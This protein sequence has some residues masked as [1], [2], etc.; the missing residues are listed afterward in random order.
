MATTETYQRLHDQ[1]PVFSYQSFAYTLVQ[2]DF[3]CAF[4]YH[5]APDLTFQHHVTFHQVDT[6][7]LS[8]QNQKLLDNLVFHLGLIEMFSYWKL[9]ASPLIRIE[10]G[11]LSPK[12]LE[13]WHQLLLDGMGEYFYVNQIPFF[14]T[15]FVRLEAKNNTASAPQDC[16]HAHQG[17][18]SLVNLGGGKDSATMLTMLE[19]SNEDFATFIIQP[20]SPAARTQ[21]ELSHRTL[22]TA[23]RR[24]DPQLTQL[25]VNGYLNGHVPFSASV[26]FINLLA[27]VFYD[28]DFCLVGNEASADEVSLFWQNQPINHQFSKST[29]F[30]QSFQTYCSQYLINNVKYFSLLRPFNEFQIA[31]IFC[32]NPLFFDSARSCNR[33]Q[34]QNIWCEHCPKCL[35]VYLLLSAFLPSE[36]LHTRI[37][38][39]SLLDD[40]SLRE[41][42]SQLLGLATAKPLE[43][44]GTRD[45]S[46]AA[47]YLLYTN[48]IQSQ[49]PLPSLVAELAPHVLATRTNWEDFV[50][51][52][53]AS[54]HNSDTLPDW[55]SDLAHHYHR[56][57]PYKNQT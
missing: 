52:L 40:S 24:F 38:S 7:H 3:D 39:H 30:E 36:V 33:G 4:T 53:N 12:Q 15:D 55:A 9:T 5:L 23:A 49:Q 8:K 41:T 29:K 42:L 50:N 32:T 10:V 21:A 2:N 37:F 13:F 16:Q 31:Q 44:V 18:R 28:Y 48:C 25:N 54:W 14:T 34:K 43:C 27:G 56:Q 20:S 47:F 6:E 26:A 57:L 35:F 11:S 17:C 22:H 1:H 46:Q 19:N 45:D 51:A